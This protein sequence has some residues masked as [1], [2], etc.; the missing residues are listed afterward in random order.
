[1]IFCTPFVINCLQAVVVFAGSPIKLI[2]LCMLFKRALSLLMLVLILFADSG[3][4]VYAHTCL[5]SKRTSLSIGSPKHCCST[6]AVTTGC[7]VKKA[8]CCEVSSKYLKQHFVSQP[9]VVDVMCHQVAVLPQSQV[10]VPRMVQPVVS[11]AANTSPPPVAFAKSAGT[12]T[13]TFRI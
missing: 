8:T 12:F 9:V 4:T 2:Y 13:Q 7:A 11:L 6:K 5:K 10:F 1:M 3:Q